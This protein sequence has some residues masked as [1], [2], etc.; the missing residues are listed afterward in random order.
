MFRLMM[1][2]ED[3]VDSQNKG[4]EFEFYGNRKFYQIL[5]Y[6]YRNLTPTL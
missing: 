2:S 6:S 3:T 4:E 1:F 5:A